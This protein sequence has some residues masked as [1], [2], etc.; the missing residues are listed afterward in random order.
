MNGQSSASLVVPSAATR[1]ES[2]ETLARRYFINFVN[3]S[4]D[5]DAAEG[6]VSAALSEAMK[7]TVGPKRALSP[8]IANLLDGAEASG[9]LS[10]DHLVGFFLFFYFYVWALFSFLPGYS[11]EITCLLTRIDQQQ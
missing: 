6:S 7:S 3:S 5:A 10:G 2:T 9:S 11:R 1:Y 8:F 4:A